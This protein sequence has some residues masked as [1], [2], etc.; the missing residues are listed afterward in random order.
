[1]FSVFGGVG[2]TEIAIKESSRAGSLS[3]P[4]RLGTTKEMIFQHLPAW[5]RFVEEP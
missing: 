4:R 5:D 3:L 1:V 2:T